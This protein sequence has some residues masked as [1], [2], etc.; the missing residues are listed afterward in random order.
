MTASNAQATLNLLVNSQVIIYVQHVQVGKYLWTA[1]ADKDLRTEN[2]QAKVE[3]PQKPP[4]I[5]G[6]G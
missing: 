1:E 6:T 2:F 4:F 3:E 5:I